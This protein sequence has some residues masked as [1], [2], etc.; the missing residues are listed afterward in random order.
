VSYSIERR[1]RSRYT[2][3][4]VREA[5]GINSRS[6]YAGIFEHSTVHIRASLGI[7]VVEVLPIPL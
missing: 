2:H 7:S 6:T 4:R 3:T 1:E 5:H